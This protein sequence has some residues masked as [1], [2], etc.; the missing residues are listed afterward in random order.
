MKQY[1]TLIALMLLTGTTLAG[2]T[3]VLQVSNVK[4]SQKSRNG[5]VIRGGKIVELFKDDR[6]TKAFAFADQMEEEARLERIKTPAKWYDPLNH[7]MDRLQ[8]LDRLPFRLIESLTQP[9]E[10]N[11]PYAR[12]QRLLDESEDL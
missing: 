3:P 7:V 12:M 8:E 5:L 10:P 6:W 4:P 9:A 1:G 2:N 11:D